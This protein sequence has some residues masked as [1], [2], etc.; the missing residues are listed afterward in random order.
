[1]QVSSYGFAPLPEP[2]VG[3]TDRLVIL[4]PPNCPS[5][6]GRRADELVNQ[7]TADGIPC[8]RA[9]GANIRADRDAT[10]D[11]LDRLNSVMLGE[12]PLVF[13]N[14]RAKNNPDLADVEGEY[15]S[16]AN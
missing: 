15:R 1:V 7:L 12:L 5:E 13:I 10:K 14:G 9:A 3:P 11:E 16:T 4:A 2:F 6:Q 8:S